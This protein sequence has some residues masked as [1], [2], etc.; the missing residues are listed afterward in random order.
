MTTEISM[1]L[2]SVAKPVLMSVPENPSPS[3]RELITKCCE[4]E[5]RG[6]QIK[7][8]RMLVGA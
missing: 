1:V 4:N 5:E 6:R 8:F 3:V 2:V 7:D